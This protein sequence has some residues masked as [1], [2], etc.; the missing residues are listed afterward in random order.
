MPTPLPR[1]AVRASTLICASLAAG[2]I[3]SLAMGIG[4]ATA[5]PSAPADT[6]PVGDVKAGMKGHGLTVFSGT[7]PE[8]FDVEVIATLRN[9]RPHQDLILI[10]TPHPRLDVAHTVAGMSGSPVYVDGKMIGAYAYGWT[11]G[12]EAIAGVTPIRS[13]LDEL[14]RPLPNALAPRP[15]KGPIPS[16]SEG[17]RRPD[18]ATSAWNLAPER[19]DLREHAARMSASMN[20]VLAAPE[21]TSLAR[22]GTAVM[23]GGMGNTATKLASELLAPMGLEP[24]QSGGGGPRDPDPDAPLH[25]EDG[26]A[27][28]VQMVRG[29]ISAMG[30]GTVT[31]V[32]GNRLVAFGHPMM[33]GGVSSLPTAIGKVHWIVAT[34]NKSFKLGEA[35]RPMGALVNDRQAAIVVDA[36]VKAPVFPMRVSI[37]GVPGA[38]HPD[39][40]VEVA[41]DPFLAPSFAAMAL[42]NAVEAT[43]SEKREMTWRAKSTVSIAGYG[44]VTISDFGAG[45]G[46]PINA[47][48]FARGKLVR[49]LGALLNNP[50]EEVRI[51]RVDTEI[52]V[53]FRLDA[54]FLRGARALNPEVEAGQPARIE[55][56]LQSRH[57][58]VESRTVEVPLPA[59]LAGRDVEIELAPG[60]EVERPL[61][62][63]D[64]VADLVATLPRQTFDAESVVASLRL[65]EIGA[66]YRGN[67]ASRLPAGASDTLRSTTQ[68]DAPET[69]VAQL[70]TAIPLKRFLAGKDTVRVRIKPALR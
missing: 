36:E 60:Y 10:K 66:S 61:P 30:L 62:T 25:Y 4:I 69:F 6:L 41:H 45:L 3:A 5:L 35:A 52:A 17:P 56:S 49:A 22:A 44:T 43:T 18:H 26:G 7:K 15:S 38:P 20:P 70:Q 2:G 32:E 37:L 63:P 46:E 33:N 8:R 16:A 40:N 19:Y 50:W 54:W 67:L 24:L 58:R 51:E 11:F 47:D 14:A 21:G 53:D 39:W 12:S 29:D 42:G 27:I 57:G 68:S 28:A 23:L 31:R 34:A 1:F 65:K 55:L 13:M 48:D 64:S 59:E 9:F